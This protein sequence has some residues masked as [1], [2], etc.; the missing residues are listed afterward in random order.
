MS[1][2]VEFKDKV[3]EGDKIETMVNWNNQ[4]RIVL[5]KNGRVHIDEYSFYW[6]DFFDVNTPLKILIEES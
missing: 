6:D 4:K 2:Y 5:F 3:S 1:F